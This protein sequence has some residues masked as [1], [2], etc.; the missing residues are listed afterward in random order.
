[1]EETRVYKPN[2]G[3]Q[4]FAPQLCKWS[5]DNDAGTSAVE[6]SH[7]LYRSGKYIV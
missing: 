6:L 7:F 5:C 2:T 3:V 1:M 4:R